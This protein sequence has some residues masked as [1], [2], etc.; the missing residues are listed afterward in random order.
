M[1]F[2]VQ[3]YGVQSI[4]REDPELFLETVTKAGY[5]YIEPC[6]ALTEISD[7]LQDHVWSVEELEKYKRLLE[8]YGV[9]IYSAHIFAENILEKA[10]ELVSITE[11]YGIR[12][13][14]CPCPCFVKKEDYEAAAEEYRAAAEK[15][16][17][18]D[19][20]LL[21]HNGGRESKEKLE[22]ISVYEWFLHRCG[23]PVGAQPDTGWLLY[24]G[25]DPEA[26]LWRNQEQ[27]CSIH[28]KDMEQAENGLQETEIGTGLLDMTACFQFAR[29]SEIL[30]IADQDGSKGELLEEIARV[31]RRFRGLT[32][33]RHN[34][35]SILCVMDSET[36]EITKLHTYD[37]IIEAPN[38]L[39]ENDD[40]L[41]YNSGGR[42]YRYQIS[43]DK[44]VM[45]DSGFCKNCN[46]DHV[47]SAD[48]TEIAVSHS[49][50][51]QESKIYIFPIEG[52][53]PRQITQNG[54]SYLHGWSP[55]KAE[56]A[57]CAFRDHGNGT[58]VDVYSIS[59]E[60][61]EERQLTSHAGFNDG[62][63]YS[64]DG[65]HIW[66][67]S[68]RTGLMQN[69]RMRRDGS[70]QEQMTFSEKNNWFGHVS[71]DGKKVVYLSYSKE[72]LDPNEH[73]PNMKVELNLMNFDG[74]ENRL[75][76][77]FFGG[78]GSINVNSWNPDS[79]RFAFVMYELR[80]K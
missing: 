36:G 58:E 27:I 22:G 9:R 31:G 1:R 55:D 17:E 35:R 69:W 49:D 26:F 43:A 46:N 45:L 18:A 62:P 74:S 64:P 59:R 44:E 72:G 32:G 57:Y 41:F 77:S 50:E 40:F 60:G 4:F 21:I 28:Y 51:G 73:L 7:T 63:E 14:V 70:R 68:T 48:S 12:Q 33:I 75:L 71:P 20:E 54:P 24:G 53:K 61:G 10:E 23:N 80:H 5:R 11:K 56:L 34:T 52:G 78:Q 37:R 39:Q 13:Y 67:I 8:K 2:G 76:L 66:F 16:R 42:I 29:A 30:Q 19:A 25:V 79:R 6:I 3:M 47:L 15:L 65:E 38:W